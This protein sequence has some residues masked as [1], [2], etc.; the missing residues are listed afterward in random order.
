W[1]V[2]DAAS[3]KPFGYMPFYPGPGIGGHCIPLDPYYL[4]S[5]AKEHDFHT[6]FIELAAEINEQMPYYVTSRIMEALNTRG[7]SL[8]G[9]GILVL[10]ATY[11]KDI[12]DS[13]ESP[14][15]K[16]IR[17]LREKGGRVSYHDPYIAEIKI[18]GDTL[19]SVELT[20][21][22]LSTADLVVIATD[23]SSYDYDYIVNKA[24]QVFDTRGITKKLK[25]NN[26][27]RL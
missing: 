14:A 23:H 10:G 7:K 5:K 17:L 16:L 26:I 11:K 21:E 20:E 19:T 4:A 22:H 15:L 3:S 1:E 8:N 12:E 6:R 27:L 2:I 18:S 24:K 9:A 13:R 25:S